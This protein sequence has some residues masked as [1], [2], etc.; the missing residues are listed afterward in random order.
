MWVHI[1]TKAKTMVLPH[2]I[3]VVTLLKLYLTKSSH[4]YCRKHQ[5]FAILVILH[6]R[7][8]NSEKFSPI[9]TQKFAF[10]QVPQQLFYKQV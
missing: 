8:Q 1:S 5:K 9:V 3:E 7:I 4:N 10:S 2:K 6:N